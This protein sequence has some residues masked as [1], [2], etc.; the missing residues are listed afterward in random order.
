[1]ALTIEKYIDWSQVRISGVR[2]NDDGQSYHSINV[3]KR[4]IEEAYKNSG[5]A[6]GGGGYEMSHY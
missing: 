3:I 4:E 1:M 5:V 6:H 2:N